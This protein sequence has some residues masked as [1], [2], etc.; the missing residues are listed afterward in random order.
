RA[1]DLEKL[2]II[3][4]YDRQ[5]TGNLERALETLELWAQTAP[6]ES[7]PHGLMAGL[8]TQCTGK[9]EKAVRESEIAIGLAPDNELSYSSLARVNILLGRFTQA[10]ATLKRASDRNF[11]NPQFLIYRYDLAFLKGEAEE[12]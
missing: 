3:Y 5:A 10:E 8:V 4:T 12:M 1:S 2:F 7:T 9:Y 6:H 11:K